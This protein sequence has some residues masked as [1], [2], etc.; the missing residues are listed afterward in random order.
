MMSVALGLVAHLVQMVSVFLQVPLRYPIVHFSSRS[1]IVDHV[2]K[3]PEKDREWV[4]KI[5]LPLILAL[6]LF[7]K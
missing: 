1:R 7:T 2:A 6:T 4:F 5:A 3:I